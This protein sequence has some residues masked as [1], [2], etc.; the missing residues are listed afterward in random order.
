MDR[1][2]LSPKIENKLIGI[3][4]RLKSLYADGLVSVILYGSAAR[5][6]FKK[7]HSNI[8]LAVILSDMSLE[9]LAKAKI[10]LSSRRY[11]M[12][13]IIFFTEEYI[14][15]SGDIFP[16]EFL[17]MRDNHRVMY[18]KDVFLGID[19]DMKHLR[20]QCEQELKEK[21]L[22]ISGFYMVNR[23]KNILTAF[24]F[25]SLNSTLHI[26]RNFIRLKGRVSPMDKEGII[27]ELSREAGSPLTSMSGILEAFKSN[28][29]LSSSEI[30]KF[31]FG[32]V[33][34]LKNIAEAVDRMS[35]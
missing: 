23:N 26:L 2:T 14:G 17:D 4:E 34:E 10:D 3:T 18:G 31:F 24:L 21:L 9:N 30:D 20:F 5:G 19:I 35:I 6:E 25:K 8:N 1:S 28:R 15:R 27:S 12:F 13:N 7:K 32:F 29:R 11:A 22:Q 33:D 16:I